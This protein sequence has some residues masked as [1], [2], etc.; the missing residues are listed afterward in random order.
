MVPSPSVRFFKEPVSAAT[1]F[2]GFVAAVAGLAYLVVATAHDGPKVAAMAVYGT[3]L[4][5]V[6]L[7]STVFHFVDLGER[8][9]RWLQ[10]L[11]HAAI[12]LLI[13]GTYAP[14]LLHL[15]DGT[16][17]VAMLG[18]VGGLALAGV[19][20][21]IVWIDCPTWLSTGTY[22]ALG[23]SAV[24][25]GYRILP[26]L[27]AGPLGW[28]VLGGLAYSVGAVVYATRWPDPW[29]DRLGHHEIWHLFVLLGA[30]AH[31]VFT[32]GLVDHPRP[33]FG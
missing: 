32:A 19:V 30:A 4:A 16:W 33:L 13:A 9:N 21:K 17:R 29:P 5:L 1:H 14:A 25:P 31:F 15:L 2:A 23:W 8:W 22:L 20:L 12:Y 10:R 18:A 6:F 11:D 24:I 27:D 28:L 7:S 3:T 26:Q